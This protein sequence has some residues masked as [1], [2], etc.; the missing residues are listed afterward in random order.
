MDTIVENNTRKFYA[1]IG[2][3]ILGVLVTAILVGL[4]FW[5]FIDI[6]SDFTNF[7]PFFIYRLKIPVCF[8]T[9][10]LIAVIVQILRF[11]IVT[12]SDEKVCVKRL[13]KKYTLELEKYYFY[14]KTEY[15]KHSISMLVFTK[16]KRCLILK[17]TAGKI[18]KIRLYSFTSGSLYDL[19][20]EIHKRETEAISDE[21]K[22]EVIRDSWDNE[23][24]FNVSSED[25]IR[26]EWKKVGIIIAV[27]V[28][29]AVC[30][31]ILL[32][33]TDNDSY[34]TFELIFMVI[35]SLICVLEIPYELIRTVKNVKRC[36]EYVEF[37][38]EHFMVGEDHFIVSDIKK[39]TMTSAD[40]KSGSI[41][42]VQR[43]IIVTC[44]EKYKYWLGSEASMSVKE[45][46]RLCAFIRQAFINYPDK[47]EFKG[48]RS[49]LNT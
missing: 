41:Y 36:P 7:I 22:A 16:H 29:L 12:V 39:L 31:T 35:V 2:K 42:P 46:K 32:I 8:F 49:W 25:I 17:D 44:T 18:I 38:G 33:F 3:I 45:Y 19:I 5:L 40:R 26:S 21:R 37:K 23:R 47:L 4:I 6:I 10:F 13:L 27:W 43:Y 11:T 28:S 1:S 24:R 14:E 48:E 20:D 15:K 30:L 34:K 9:G